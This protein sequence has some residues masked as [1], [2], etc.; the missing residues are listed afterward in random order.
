M[1]TMCYKMYVLH[2][3]EIE[4]DCY[5]QILYSLCKKDF[6]QPQLKIEHILFNTH[7]M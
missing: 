5:K 2:K 1:F 6:W 7:A 3:E 4:T